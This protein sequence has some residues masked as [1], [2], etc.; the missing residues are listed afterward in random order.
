M[1]SYITFPNIDSAIRRFELF[2]ME[3]ALRWYALAY[4]AGI[5]IGLWIIK[6]LVR[7]AH[8]W[9][10]NRAP[11]DS[12]GVDDIL[13]Y[14]VLGIILG[15]RMG[16]VLFYQPGRFLD[17]PLA[18]FR[19][20]EGGM[21]FHGGM[22]GVALGIL[23][24]CRTRGAPVLSV[25]DA[26]ALSAPIG[27]FLGRLANFVNGELW[28]RPTTMPWGVLFPDPRSQVC[29]PWWEGV[30]A[31]H[32]SQL[33]EAAL[34]GLL[35]MAIL[36]VCLR[37]GWLKFPGRLAG[38]FLAGYGI[39]RFFVEY[40]R[41]ADLQFVTADNPIGFAYR[42]GEFGVTMGQLLSLPMIAIGLVFVAASFRRV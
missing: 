18:I 1:Q 26:F 35:L 13:T 11:M 9:P 22:L 30:C 40:F 25:A 23:W 19:I 15:G 39:A 4:I 37:A 31:R 2:G 20:W 21:A 14:A 36:L 7:R 38:I 8:L 42:F 41:Q 29:P 12:A 16:Y 34:E 5:L 24:F 6:R 3:F 17:D 27:L 33:Y 32:P 10:D 28:G